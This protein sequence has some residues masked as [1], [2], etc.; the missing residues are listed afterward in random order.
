MHGRAWCNVAGHTTGVYSS[1][2]RGGVQVGHCL[3]LK[4]GLLFVQTAQEI[5]NQLHTKNDVC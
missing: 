2:K 5:S 1:V 4:I 3:S